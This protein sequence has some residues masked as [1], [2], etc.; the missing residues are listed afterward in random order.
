MQE[1]AH[2]AGADAPIH[3]EESKQEAMDVVSTDTPADDFTAVAAEN[4]DTPADGNSPR[5][6][7][8]YGSVNMFLFLR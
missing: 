7:V 4:A 8:V 2:A 1:D 6:T 5:E 3:K